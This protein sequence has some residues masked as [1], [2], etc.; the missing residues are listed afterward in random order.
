M[1]WERRTV[2][3]LMKH[4]AFG[5][6][7]PL[8]CWFGSHIPCQRYCE[9]NAGGAV[10]KVRS[11]C[12]SCLKHRVGRCLSGNKCCLH[13]SHRLN[14]AAPGTEGANWKNMYWTER[15]TL[16]IHL[17]LVLIPV[18][19]QWRDWYIYASQFEPPFFFKHKL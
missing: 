9:V 16:L 6:S 13:V 3:G 8:D 14:Q 19:Y 18:S 7:S 12:V 1:Q 10:G 2:A 15:I 17:L 11:C 5:V 4:I